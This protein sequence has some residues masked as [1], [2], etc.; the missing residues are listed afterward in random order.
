MQKHTFI[1]RY[2]HS[3][4]E[5]LDFRHS[6]ER[7]INTLYS[8]L[9]NLHSVGDK[10]KKLFDCNIKSS[11]E[12]KILRI[13]RNYFHHVGDVEEVRLIAAVEE[14][15]VM[16]H[17]QHIILPLETFAKSLKSFIDSN[18]V[19]GRKDYKR[20]MTFVAKELASITECFSYMN[21]ILPNIV[22]WPPSYEQLR[23]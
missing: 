17:S 20:K 18:V 19:E 1:D 15:V 8:Y 3:Q 13:I 2:F 22:R 6:D 14:N 4:K 9:N 7:D 11:P 16:A 23:C 21:D 5:L 12:F 10:L